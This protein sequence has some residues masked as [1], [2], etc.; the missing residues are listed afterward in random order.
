M[1]GQISNIEIGTREDRVPAVLIGLQLPAFLNFRLLGSPQR[2]CP[3]AVAV[4]QRPPLNRAAADGYRT[5]G[6]RC[7]FSSQNSKRLSGLWSTP[8][9]ETERWQQTSQ[10]RWCLPRR[11]AKK[12]AESWSL[13]EIV[14]SCS[15]VTIPR[16]SSARPWI[17]LSS[18]TG[19]V[20]QR[21]PL[22]Q[23][24]MVGC[25]ERESASAM[26]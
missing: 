26:R 6:H 22:N 23:H 4:K 7:V 13:T 16:P 3:S 18:G 10:S 5:Q 12:R 1:P 2:A 15:C 21:V 24:Q 14:W 20:R 9:G 11:H 25:P 8:A 17:P 19:G